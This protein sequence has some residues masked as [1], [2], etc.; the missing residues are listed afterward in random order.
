MTAAEL[1]AELKRVVSTG[2]LPLRDP[3]VRLMPADRVILTGSVPVA[4]F[5]IPV[6][7][8]ARLIVEDGRIHV[9][10]TRVE[11]VG[12]QLPRELAAQLGQQVNDQGSQAIQTALPPGR[13]ARRVTVDTERILVQLDP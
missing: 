8:E 6:E 7:M 13:R 10:T 9:A 2:G 12:A 5:Q 3:A 1:D 4:I 11:A